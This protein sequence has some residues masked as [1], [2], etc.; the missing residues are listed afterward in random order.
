MKN[1]DGR[2]LPKEVQQ[3]NRG[4]AIRLF[5]GGKVKSKVLGHIRMLQKK[6]W[7]SE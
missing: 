3:H 7:T 1:T 2:N 4:Q 6:V 5:K